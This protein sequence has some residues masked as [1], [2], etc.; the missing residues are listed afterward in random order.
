MQNNLSF[1]IKGKFGINIQP[2]FTF[3]KFN[4][5]VVKGA[6]IFNKNIKVGLAYAIP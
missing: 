5:D 1:L 6:Q 3:K 4:I 2:D